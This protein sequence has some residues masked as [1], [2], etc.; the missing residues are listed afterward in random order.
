M[1]KPRQELVSQSAQPMQA[2]PY[3]DAPSFSFEQM[4][5]MAISMANAKI[6]GI[7]NADQA[8]TLMLIAHSEGKHPA[9]IARDFDLINNK[10]AKKAEAIMRDFQAS[11]G[12]IE[13]HELTDKMA[14]A[15]FTHP[16]AVKPLKIDWDIARA[17]QA[18][19]VDKNGGMYTKYPRAMLRSRCVAEGCRAQAPQ[20]TSGF[21]TPEELQVYDEVPEP[22]A[23]ITAAIEQTVDALASDH[24][25]A[26][27][28][29]MDVGTLS[30]LEQSFAAAWRATKDP[31]LRARFKAVYDG[32]RAEIE[33]AMPAAAPKTLEEE[34][35]GV[36]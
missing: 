36:S 35:G 21:H 19:L 31:V 33:R 13:W 8:L 9:T 15:T 10:P 18:G 4:Q 34:V 12:R 23:S 7:A 22:A 16:L 28:N 29:S 25:E 5:R 11:G 27:I 26:L 24:I 6:F 32:Q 30:A 20:S 17:K 14:S 2:Q 1:T 3:Q